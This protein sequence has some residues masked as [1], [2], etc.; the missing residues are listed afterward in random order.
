[1]NAITPQSATNHARYV[2]GFHFVTAS[3]IIV[4]FLWSL[5]HLYAV[6]DGVSVALAVIAF[7]LISL[8]WYARTFAVSV[9]DRVIRLEERLRLAHVLPP[10]LLARCEEFTPSQLIALRFASDAELPELARKVLASGIN[11]RATIKGMITQ[12]RPDYM[13]T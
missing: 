7:C 5:Y 1:M 12:W 4:T 8:F 6:R 10:D 3:L 2:P 13:R 9:Q 11:D